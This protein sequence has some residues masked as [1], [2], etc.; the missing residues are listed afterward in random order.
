MWLW[1]VW[2]CS[3]IGL[4]SPHK[5]NNS[6]VFTSFHW[7]PKISFTL[8]GN[9][10]NVLGQAETKQKELFWQIQYICV[11]HFSDCIN[12]LKKS[13]VYKYIFFFYIY[14][15]ILISIN[16]IQW[17]KKLKVLKYCWFFHLCQNRH[18]TL[19]LFI[20]TSMPKSFT[21][22]FGSDTTWDF[23]P[24]FNITILSLFYFNVS[25]ILTALI[26]VFR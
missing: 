1:A 17:A 25:N 24:G 7:N 4:L 12:Y 14:N 20:T 21:L 9:T 2:H 23:E 8:L 10:L 11:W 5:K 22:L 6:L 19:Y 15:T 18:Q 16:H 13:I 26:V 3:A